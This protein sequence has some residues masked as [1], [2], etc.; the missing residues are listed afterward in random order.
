MFDFS[1]IEEIRLSEGAHESAAEG[2]CFME[3]ISFFAGE[4]HSDHPECACPVLT[5][6][7]ITLNDW[8][9]DGIR[10]RLLRPLV[11]LVAGTRDKDNGLKRAEF[12]AVWA[13][14]KVLPIILRERGFTGHAEACEDARTLDE[15]ASAAS[16]AAYAN[17]AYAA[18]ANSAEIWTVAVEGL[19]QAILI[20]R[21]DGFC[22]ADAI[23]AERHEKLKE[24]VG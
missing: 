2:V 17:A 10:N 1:K 9:P 14:N 24:L 19:R 5:S 18:A 11:P 6:Y 13:T 16:A 20:G 15:A 3:A 23:L 22:I 7:G 8:M 4:K 12:L 21:H